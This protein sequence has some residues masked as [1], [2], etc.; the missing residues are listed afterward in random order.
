MKWFDQINKVWLSEDFRLERAWKIEMAKTIAYWVMDWHQAVRKSDLCLK[1][2]PIIAERRFTPVYE[3]P[4][5]LL[6]EISIDKMDILASVENNIEMVDISSSASDEKLMQPF[7]ITLDINTNL[8]YSDNITDAS[9][10]F[11]TF[12]P[13]KYSED[14]IFIEKED[15]VPVSYLFD[16]EY[17]DEPVTD[18]IKP[19]FGLEK[20]N[21]KKDD[22][23]LFTQCTI[24]EEPYKQPNIVRPD[25]LKSNP[26]W[27]SDEED[28]LWQ[29]SNTYS[30]NWSLVA[31][32]L[33]GLRIGNS[34]TR[35]EFCC[36][37][38][39]CELVA[40]D[41]ISQ[42]KNDYLQTPLH[43][44]KKDKK[45]KV[46]GLLGTFNFIGGLVKKRENSRTTGNI[47]LTKRPNQTNKLILLRMI[48]TGKPRFR[49]E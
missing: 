21:L 32:S 30:G 48:H 14:A 2:K 16:K 43:I 4:I 42:T 24:Q 13:P 29:L 35:T 15:I 28:A 11:L 44:N 33:N 41:Y 39:Y 3:K 38:K 46:L 7:P 10:Q 17:F 49:P 40:K 9:S 19:L 12:G 34:G 20:Y 27:I 31:E 23:G 36:F 18:S 5:S 26:S 8:Y 25:N 6:N 22:I 1:T 45:V 47:I 37:D